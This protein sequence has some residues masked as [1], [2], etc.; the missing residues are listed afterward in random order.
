MK[1]LIGQIHT[2][3]STLWSILLTDTLAVVFEAAIAVIQLVV[4]LN[5]LTHFLTVP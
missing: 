2:G 3:N 5:A 4:T 1:E